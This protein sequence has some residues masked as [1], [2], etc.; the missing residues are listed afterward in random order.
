MRADSLRAFLTLQSR[1]LPYYSSI[2]HATWK[3]LRQHSLPFSC[4][5]VC[6]SALVAAFWNPAIREWEIWGVRAAV[7]L[8]ALTYFAQRKGYT[9][10]RYPLLVFVLLWAGMEFCRAMRGKGLRRLYG[11]VCLGAAVLFI[12]PPGVNGLRHARH[13]S[14]PFAD[15][16]QTDLIR[17]GGNDLQGRVQCLDLVTGCYSALYRL[18]LMQSTGWMGDLELFGPDDH[19]VVPHARQIFWDQI[20]RDPPKVI[21][22]SSEWFGAKQY[23]FDKLNAWPQFRDYLNAT[24]ML[25]VTR[26]F[27]SFDDNELAYRIYVRRD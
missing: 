26:T 24:Y 15:Q 9:Y 5:V 25:E 6:A 10:H 17:L 18:G 4:A 22:L 12:L 21:V 23:S 19:N 16:L 11:A 8:G 2:G 3:Y 1:S 7:L 27:G 14:N 20:Q 13:D